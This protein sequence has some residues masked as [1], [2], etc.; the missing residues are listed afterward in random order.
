MRKHTPEKQAEEYLRDVP[1]D[2]RF[3]CHNGEVYS[4]L[5]DLEKGLRAM[6]AESFDYHSGAGR[7][8]FAE[9][10]RNIIGD[11]FLA[12]EMSQCKTR[13]RML[14]SVSHRV[15]WLRS[16]RHTL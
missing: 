15:S 1:G 9:W 4:T 12:N 14:Q 13:L 10:V 3:W 11:E 5:I 6:T 16:H 7:S 8:D 2:V